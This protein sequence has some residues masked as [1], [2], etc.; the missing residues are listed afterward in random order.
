MKDFLLRELSVVG[1]SVYEAITNRILGCKEDD[2][3]CSAVVML[4][5]CLPARKGKGKAR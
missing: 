2:A 4:S 3:T 5:E 1:E